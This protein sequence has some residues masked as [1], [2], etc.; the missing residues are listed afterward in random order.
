MND[1]KFNFKHIHLGSLLKARTQELLLKSASLC[2][3]FGCETQ[4]LEKMYDSQSL[5]MELIVKWSKVLG[6]DFFRIYSTHLILYAPQV[7]QVRTIETKPKNPLEISFRKN[8]YTKEIIDFILEML[9]TGEK[10]KG[11]IIEEYG[12]PNS[13]LHKWLD[14]YPN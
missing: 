6:Y 10:S 1:K 4:D 13:T 8:I 11:Q 7:T 9:S 3:F 5:D 2:A 12:I 14:K